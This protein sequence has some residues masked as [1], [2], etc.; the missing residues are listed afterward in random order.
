MATKDANLQLRFTSDGSLN[1]DGFTSS[2]LRLKGAPLEGYAVEVMVPAEGGAT[3]RTLDIY[4]F[5][6][7]ATGVTSASGLLAQT[8][9]QLVDTTAIG[10]HIIP[11]NL[12]DG[13]EYIVLKMD[14]GGTS[15]DFSVVL[16]YVVEN[17][18]VKPSRSIHFG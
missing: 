16:A 13:Y 12:P 1:S 14:T 5:G 15:V 6:A 3:D 9:V 18:G 2:E 10:T 4:I 17:V 11:F 7:T 8:P